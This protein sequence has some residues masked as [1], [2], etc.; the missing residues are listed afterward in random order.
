MSAAQWMA[1]QLQRKA[2]GRTAMALE[3]P[4]YNPHPAGVIREGSASQAILAYL[5]A[6][7]PGRFVPSAELIKAT[8]RPHS[9]VSWSLVYLR[10][11]GLVEVVP[12]G[13]R[14]PRY[15]RYRLVR[16]AG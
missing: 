4:R 8:G 3:V 10:G 12:D 14:N 15:N 9:A 13:A 6:Q 16:G 11:L 1:A 2:D 5:G 7:Q